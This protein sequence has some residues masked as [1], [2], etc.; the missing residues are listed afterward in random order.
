MSNLSQYY[1]TVFDAKS[2]PQVTF[3]VVDENPYNAA[4]QA[5][6]QWIVEGVHVPL[7]GCKVLVQPLDLS[8][9]IESAPRS[10]T[11]SVGYDAL[12][13]MESL[14]L[15]IESL[16]FENEPRDAVWHA[17]YGACVARQL[18]DHGSI[19]YRGYDFEDRDYERWSEEAEHIADED[20]A[21]R[22]RRAG[23]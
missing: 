2:N 17:V 8:P 13:I 20:A 10:V 9:M 11:P 4:S 21:A 1:V 22:K 7:K 15:I 18:F 5:C 14:G 23:T 16:G 12:S 3:C 6:R 19:S